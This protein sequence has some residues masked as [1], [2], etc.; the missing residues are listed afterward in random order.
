MKT[1]K[2]SKGPRKPMT[3]QEMIKA[4]AAI[5]GLMAGCIFFLWLAAR[6]FR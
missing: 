6:F 3:R 4:A 5:T 2:P 1:S